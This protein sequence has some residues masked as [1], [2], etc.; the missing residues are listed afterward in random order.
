MELNL[1]RKFTRSTRSSRSVAEHEVGQRS[2]TKYSKSLQAEHEV[3][4]EV[5][6]GVHETLAEHE[7]GH[8][9]EALVAEHV[10]EL[11][12]KPLEFLK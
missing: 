11:V 7:V 9:V 1:Y 4:R 12:R 2:Y 3:E 8:E 6:H 10:V 5:V